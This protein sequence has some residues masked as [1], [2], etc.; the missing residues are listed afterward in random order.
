[1]INTRAV[2]ARMLIMG[3]TQPTVAELMGMN[4]ATFNAKIHNKSRL[5][6]DEHIKISNILKLKTA[7]EQ[8]E[9]LGVALI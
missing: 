4:V 7:D 5:Y 6:V 9:L 8:K 1:M 2:K 3:L